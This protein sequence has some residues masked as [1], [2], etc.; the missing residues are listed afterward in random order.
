MGFVKEF[1][2]FAMRGNVM[3]LAVGVVIGGAFNEIVSKMVDAIIMP[4]VGMFT[5]DVSKFDEITIGPV[6]IGLL[7]HAI[8]N[9]VVIAFALFQLVKAINRFKAKT[10][11]EAPAP[12]KSEVLLGEIRDALAKR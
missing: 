8:F 6:K 4:I 12:T 9:F 3:D 2:D 7:I 10:V 5:G 1:K 11:Q